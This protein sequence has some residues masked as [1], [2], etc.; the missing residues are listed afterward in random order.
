[1]SKTDKTYKSC[2]ST[3][4]RKPSARKIQQPQQRNGKGC[5]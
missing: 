5:D 1:M 4:Y 2:I 3:K